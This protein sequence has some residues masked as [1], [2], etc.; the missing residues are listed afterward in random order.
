MYRAG[1]KWVYT[2]LR[3]VI[4]IIRHPFGKICSYSVAAN[5][6]AAIFYCVFLFFTLVYKKLFLLSLESMTLFRYNEYS[7]EERTPSRM[8]EKKDDNNMSASQNNN[9]PRYESKAER[10]AAEAAQQAQERKKFRNGIIACSAALAV[11]IVFVAVFGSNLFYSGTTSIVIDGMEYTVADYNFF[12]V[13][14]YNAYREGLIEQ[15]GEDNASYYLPI[16]S[17]S[18]KNQIFDEET[19]KTWDE[20]LEERA[21]SIMRTYTALYHEATAAG[22]EL[23]DESIA[24]LD[25]ERI[26]IEENAKSLGYNSADAYLK[27]AYGKGMDVERYF[28]NREFLTYVVEYSDSIIGALEYTQEELDAEYDENLASDYDYVYFYSMFV[29]ADAAEDQESLDKEM[30]EAKA[31][32]EA[33]AANIYDA[34]SFSSMAMSYIMQNLE[35]YGGETVAY[36]SKGATAAN[37]NPDYKDWLLDDARQ[38]GDTT[39]I[40][41]GGEMTDYYNGYHLV[42]YQGRDSHDYPAI[43]GYYVD[44]F[45]EQVNEE[46]YETDEAYQEA[47]NKAIANAESMAQDLIDD[48]NSGEFA[49]FTD[50]TS[51]YSL[52]INGGS[53]LSQ[54]GK[55]VTSVSAID[56]WF[57]NEPRTEGD[58]ECL[59]L[60][61][62]VYVLLFE[63]YDDDY[64]DVLADGSLR[65][66]ALEELEQ[67]MLESTEYTTSWTFRFAGNGLL[68][69]EIS[70]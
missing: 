57:F 66:A 56:N 5:V 49:T 23:S 27:V 59:T 40:G 20:F 68:V 7:R 35:D 17:Q 1:Y 21:I 64:R 43:N 61:D 9:A 19:G 11:I 12:Y 3:G 16:N 25:A 38:P 6:F 67:S 2:A 69:G 48:W 29:Y 13:S 15:V 53:R 18:L 60:D 41:I 54:I 62:K 45:V 55:Y 34:E 37:L 10:R 8:T 36:N 39:V 65:S 22:Y 47:F 46:D 4:F 44:M 26:S 51:K 70:Y 33:L 31:D 42:M 32:A 52:E 50:L 14:Q 63:N 28:K 58:I 30:A 24:N